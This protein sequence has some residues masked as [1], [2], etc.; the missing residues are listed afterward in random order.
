M[1]YIVLYPQNGDRIVT[2]ESVIS[3]HLMYMQH[4]THLV[5]VV[6]RITADKGH[7]IIHR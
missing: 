6:K 3:L 1:H 7:N 2:I 4:V 5:S